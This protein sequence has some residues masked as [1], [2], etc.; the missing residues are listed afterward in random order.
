MRL[1]IIVLMLVLGAFVGGCTGQDTGQAT[2]YHNNREHRK[3]VNNPS[4]KPSF[5]NPNTGDKLFY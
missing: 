2:F 4:H 5:R 3:W 1:G